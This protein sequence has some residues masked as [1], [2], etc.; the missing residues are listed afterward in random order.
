M[1]HLEE[2][3]K[4]NFYQVIELKRPKEEPYV[5]SNVL[6][7]AEA[8]L[9]RND[10]QVRPQAIYADDTLVGFTMTYDE[11]DRPVRSLWRILI[12]EEYTNK[13]YGS[14]ALKLILAEARE[15]GGLEKVE[16]SYVPGNTM[17]E[18]V[19]EQVGF[20]ANGRIDD[21]EVVM[22]YTL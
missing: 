1:V 12:P 16:L 7:L 3:T 17:A 4:E 20:R 11:L 14:Q 18:H 19:Y 22:E 13:G 8:W 21:G 10:G 9:Y 6:S 5:A 15:Q 2:I